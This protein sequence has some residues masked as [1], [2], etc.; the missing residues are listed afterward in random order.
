VVP[1]PHATSNADSAEAVS[2]LDTPLSA[3]FALHF[4]ENL[5]NC[6]RNPPRVPLLY[7][8][9]VFADIRV[10]SVVQALSINLQ[11]RVTVYGK[12]QYSSSIAFILTYC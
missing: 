3:P 2:N 9:Q 12:K 1:P 4:I 7:A 11:T 6:G 5:I 10:K 8:A